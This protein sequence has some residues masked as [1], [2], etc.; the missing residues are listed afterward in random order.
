MRRS[1]SVSL[2]LACLCVTTC[3]AAEPES[4][5]WAF[6]S[7]EAG[8]GTRV[9]VTA[10]TVSKLPTV[11]WIKEWGADTLYLEADPGRATVSFASSTVRTL[12]TSQGM[13]GQAVGGAAFGLALGAFV[14][15][16]IAQAVAEDDPGGGMGFSD[17]GFEEA[18]VAGGGAAVLGMVTGAVVGSLIKSERWK[19]VRP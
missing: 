11:G 3:G 12:E 8:V 4:N 18:A 7:D 14:G 16:I 19:R 1:V 15:L 9:R 2:A 13:K 5:P 6:D 10:P 17:S